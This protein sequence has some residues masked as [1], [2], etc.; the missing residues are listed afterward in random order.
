MEQSKSEQNV[1]DWERTGKTEW[2]K[3]FNVFNTG[4][5]Q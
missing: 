3:A 4:F 5:A 2:K 1:K